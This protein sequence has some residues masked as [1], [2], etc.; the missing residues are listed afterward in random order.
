MTSSSEQ[1]LIFAT[2][3]LYVQPSFATEMSQIL[4][5]PH[6]GARVDIPPLSGFH[7]QVLVWLRRVGSFTVARRLAIGSYRSLLSYHPIY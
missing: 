6:N 2:I 5:A 3:D 4:Q 1:P 7:S